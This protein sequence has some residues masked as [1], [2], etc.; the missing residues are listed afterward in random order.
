MLY[1]LLAD[2]FILIKIDDQYPDERNDNIYPDNLLINKTHVHRVR[3]A[4]TNLEI[5]SIN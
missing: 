5:F 2:H 3:V 1:I 4:G